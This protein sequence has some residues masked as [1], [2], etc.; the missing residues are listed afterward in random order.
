MAITTIS[1]RDF[2]QDTGGAKR[3]AELGPVFITDR[4]HTAHVLLTILEYERLSRRGNLK[5][6]AELLWMSGADTLEFEVITSKD[7]PRAAELD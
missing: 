6:I 2:N 3:A 5:T 1:S 7:E 4:G